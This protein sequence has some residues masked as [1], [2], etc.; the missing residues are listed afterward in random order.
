LVAP[1]GEELLLVLFLFIIG[2]LKMKALVA[3]NGGWLV[4]LVVVAFG[5]L[6]PVLG[7][8]EPTLTIP[9]VDTGILYSAAG[10]VFAA[11]VIVVAII[12]G[13]RMLKKA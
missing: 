5:L 9:D 1:C 10:K 3:R 2:V 8:C 6:L 7:Y 4:A 11:R 12:L 13:I